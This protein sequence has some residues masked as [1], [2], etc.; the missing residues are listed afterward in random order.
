MLTA[1]SPTS[2]AT[3]PTLTLGV[4][5]LLSMLWPAVNQALRE[6]SRL[7]V[8]DR[9]LINKMLGRDPLTRAIHHHGLHKFAAITVGAPGSALPMA[10][11]NKH[12]A[13]VGTAPVSEKGEAA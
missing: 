6:L 5:R 12:L 10:G 7:D 13:S 2:I 1:S 4:A 9:S 8:A 3:S 11:M